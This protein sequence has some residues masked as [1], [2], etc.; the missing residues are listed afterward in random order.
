M[1]NILFSLTALMVSCCFSCQK[2]AP[3]IEV[4]YLPGT[5][6]GGYYEELY[7]NDTLALV[8]E[9]RGFTLVLNEDGSGTYDIQNTG[10]LSDIIWSRTFDHSFIFLSLIDDFDPPDYTYIN[11]RFEVLEDEEDYQLWRTT[12]QLINNN[13]SV[14]YIYWELDKQ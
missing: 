4:A 7:K 9:S 12:Q 3:A 13:N 2:Q 1:K 5:W 11:Y 10:T 6:Q 14:R 8:E